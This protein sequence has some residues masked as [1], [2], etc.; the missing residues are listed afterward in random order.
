MTQHRYLTVEE[1]HAKHLRGQPLT[2]WESSVYR[3]NFRD[4]GT[5]YSTDP[6]V[7]RQ[8]YQQD[9]DAQMTRYRKTRS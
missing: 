1:I 5:R 2:A 9:I 4:D 6:R 3:L 8:Q 7:R